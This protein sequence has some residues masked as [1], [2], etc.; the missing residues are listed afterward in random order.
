[1]ATASGSSASHE[2]PKGR[3]RPDLPLI[4]CGKCERKIVREYRVKKKGP[5]NGRIFYTCPNR[6][7]SSFLSCF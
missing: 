4:A 1:M 3:L 6:D 2:V 5:N 7:V